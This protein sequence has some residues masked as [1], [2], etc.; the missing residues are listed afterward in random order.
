MAIT[1]TGKAV[2]NIPLARPEMI[3]VAEPVSLAAAT[4]WEGF[5]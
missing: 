4:F 5:W 2:E 1:R 3:F